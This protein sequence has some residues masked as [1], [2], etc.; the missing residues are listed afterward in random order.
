MF[1]K[2]NRYMTRAISELIPLEVNI[3]L[4]DLIEKLSIGK[5]YLQ[6]FELN[7]VGRGIVEIT[8]KQEISEYECRLY[9]CNENIV[10][11]LKIYAIDSIEYST[12]NYHIKCNI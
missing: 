3:L 2:E 9:I 4:W 12:I 10:D 5:D 1:R 7:S 8:H 6:K 11:K